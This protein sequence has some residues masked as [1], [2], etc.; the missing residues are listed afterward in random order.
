MIVVDSSAAVLGLLNEGDARR[1]L[2]DEAVAV[3]HLADAETANALRSGVRRG[4]R[5]NP[6]KLLQR[7]AQ[8]T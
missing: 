6:A 4:G 3:P 7:V 8:P 2:A 1:S 5:W